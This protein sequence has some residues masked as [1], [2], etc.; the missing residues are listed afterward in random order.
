MVTQ[1]QTGDI[2]DVVERNEKQ[3]DMVSADVESSTQLLSFDNKFY[4]VRKKL[5][6]YQDFPEIQ[7]KLFQA[8]TH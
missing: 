2:L 3:A 5:V 4:N 7:K 8:K 6:E 1:S